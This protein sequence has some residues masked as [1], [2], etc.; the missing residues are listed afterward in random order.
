MGLN[1]PTLDE[2]RLDE[3][4]SNVSVAFTQE[5][6]DYVAGTVAPVI[7]VQQPAGYYQRI[8]KGEMFR[9]RVEPRPMGGRPPNVG[10]R[11]TRDPY[12]VEEYALE[13]S[14]DDRA[15][16]NATPP[17]DPEE[18]KVRQITEEHM[19]NR[20]SLWAAEYFV[21]GQWTGNTEQTG[22]AAAPGAN[23]FLQFDVAGSDPIGVVQA[24][25]RVLKKNTGK[26][27][28]V[29]V[30]GSKVFDDLIE[31][32]DIISRYVNVEPG[33]IGKS[34]LAEVF[35]RRGGGRVVV[36]D[37]IQNT[38][39]VGAADSMDFILDE[40]AMLLAYVTSSPGIDVPTAMYT[41]AWTGL[42]GPNA[43]QT[44]GVWRGRD[45]RAHSDWFQVRMAYSFQIVSS[46]L[47]VFFNSAV[48]S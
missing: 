2:A 31:H 37:A 7:P 28:N 23:Q 24:Q 9:N 33:V 14:L 1:A 48:G 35:F 17:Y 45:G 44:V 25:N 30:L 26:W 11:L 40:T 41:F 18:S 19:I 20:D 39:N 15:R 13:G 47:A 22:V 3:Q 6:S 29:L 32:P 10:H 34:Q 38:A 8:P 21:T 27:G 4:L 43:F 36:A 16:A 5:P 12:A 46:D 42:L